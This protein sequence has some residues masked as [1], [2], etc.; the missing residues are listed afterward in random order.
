MGISIA[1]TTKRAAT[2]AALALLVVACTS[3]ADVSTT[4]TTTAAPVSST[5]EQSRPVITEVAVDRNE[6]DNYERVDMVV[7]L[8]AEFTNP[9][10]QREV[11]LEAVFR[12]PD[13]IEMAVPG[14]WDG[15]DAWRIRFTPSEV[16][17]WSYQVVAIDHRGPSDPVEGQFSVT[18]SERHGWLQVGSWVDPSYS[19]HYFAFHDGTPWYGRGHADLSMTLDGLEAGTGFRAFS[20]MPASGENYVMWWPMWANN[21]MARAYDDYAVAQM[22]IIDL[23]LEDAEAKGATVIYTIW[24]HQFLRT[25]DHPWGKAK[26]LENGFSRLTDVAGFFTDDESW[27]WQENYYRYTIAR[28]GYSTAIGMWQTIT[29]I[30][31]T[32]SYDQ[33]DPWHERLN[34]Y[35]LEHD[36][37]RHPTTATQ[38]GS[39]DWPEGHRLMD[40][41]QMHV[42]EF[43]QD[44]IEAAARMAM[45][46]E[47]MWNREEK[48]NWIGEYGEE[49]PQFYPELFHNSNWASLGAGAAMTPTE[50]NDGFAFDQFTDEMAADMSRLA[51]F[52]EG[53]PLVTLGPVPLQIVSREPEVRGWGVAGDSGGLLWV[54]DFALEGSTM[55]EIRADQTVRSGVEV[56]LASLASGTWVVTPY[57][58]RQGTWQEPFTVDCN[59]PC[60]LQL[61]DFHADM[62]F[63]LERG[64]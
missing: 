42:Y 12:G 61:P 63:K 52:V 27:A 37:Y 40:V 60:I 30:N 62:A 35:F 3:G 26:W 58:T 24:T 11:A 13:G 28:W 31:G 51:A 34:A 5:G 57:D 47:T 17:D 16:G 32:E 7:T 14:F 6:V 56:E 38:S 29:E 41:P 10:D 43:T 21:F 46:T 55:D 15:R 50:W 18:T 25:N 44:P 54:Q 22:E 19:F 48:P 53:I 9:Y 2:R 49:G 23:V 4:T 33:T 20:E 8:D 39:V 59:Q 64:E 45:W 36:P 1:L